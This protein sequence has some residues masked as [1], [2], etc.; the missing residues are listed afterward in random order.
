M[1]RIFKQLALCGMAL[2]AASQVVLAAPSG[3]VRSSSLMVDQAEIA[4]VNDRGDKLI[5]GRGKAG[6][7]LVGLENLRAPYIESE[8]KL[9]SPVTAVAIQNGKKNLVGLENGNLVVLD[10]KGKKALKTYNLNKKI[11]DIAF[12]NNGKKAVLVGDGQIILADFAKGLTEGTFSPIVFDLKSVTGTRNTERPDP[13]RVTISKERNIAAVSL[14]A[15][16]SILLIDLKDGSVQKI[17]PLGTVMH[18]ADLKRDGHV[19][20]EESFEGHPEPSGLVFSPKGD[21]LYT[22][23]GGS[24]KNSPNENGVWSGGRNYT[25]YDLEKNRLAFDSYDKLEQ[26]AALVGAYLDSQSEIRGIDPSDAAIGFVDSTPVLAIASRQA[27][28]VFFLTL[29]YPANPFYLSLTASAG[30]GSAQV[31]YLPG[32]EAFVS[33][34]AIDGFL[35]IYTEV[36]VRRETGAGY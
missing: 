9:E 22:A 21:L 35:S 16:N 29:K 36:D 14:Q 30:R 7:A 27:N 31:H 17:M 25:V 12:Y 19:W 15:N 13:V 3:F 34:D 11:V 4:G 24:G 18:L 20:L 5:V 23:N 2:V 26:S 10:L 28:G 8:M 32:R 33:V 1:K 6:V